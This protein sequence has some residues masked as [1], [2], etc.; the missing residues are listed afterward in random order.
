MAYERDTDA[1]D[2][3][4]FGRHSLSRPPSVTNL[5]DV[6]DDPAH[7]EIGRDRLGVH[8]AWE[9]V[10][11]LGAIALGY[12]LFANHRDAISGGALKTLLVF[13][14]VLG[15]LALAAS[16]SLRVGAPNLALGSVAVA[17]ALYYAQKSGGG[18]I[19]T[20]TWPVV[21]ALAL[22]V[23]MAVLVVGFQ[24]PGWAGSLVATLV[25]IAWI[26]NR[27]QSPLSV[28]GEFD[29]TK[30]AYYLIGGFVLLSLVGGLL[31]L[32][33][34]IRRGVG[35]F[36]PVGDPA[37]RRG[38]VAASVTS[39]GLI[40]STVLAAIAGIVMAAAAGAANEQITPS[41]GLEFTGLALGIALLGGASA[42]GRRGGVFGTVLATT[43]ITLL[44]TYGEQANWKISIWVLAAGAVGTGLVVTRLVETFGRPLSLD[45]GPDDWSD[46]GV[47]GTS[48][49]SAAPPVTDAWSGLS[50]P[51]SP[52][53][54]TTTSQWG[55]ETDRWR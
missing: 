26:Q 20:A 10:L 7:G 24:V 53:A 16:I 23:G 17:S 32:I 41:A 11:A 50:A 8:F 19:P 29:P 52:A 30:H 48:S 42:Y 43:V 21:L 6:F 39:L 15:L 35:R 51:T 13:G 31:G 5:E 22:G 33:K 55:A 4:Q 12:L 28:A 38:G 49:W 14:A 36:R 9:G 25:A 40:L 18:L 2:A 1:T 37:S 45:D 47:G 54:G 44:I 3:G 34:P 27:F 46:V